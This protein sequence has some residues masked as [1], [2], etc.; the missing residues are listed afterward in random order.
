MKHTQDIILRQKLLLEF[1]FLHLDK[2]TVE[3]I[4]KSH[5]KHNK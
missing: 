1:T 3:Q 4:Y 5:N 2:L